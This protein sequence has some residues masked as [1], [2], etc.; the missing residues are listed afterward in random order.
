M[1]NKTIS[2]EELIGLRVKILECTDPTWIGQSGLILDETK[3][4]FLIE[5]ENKKK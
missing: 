5:I 3:N 2:R 4:T 1:N